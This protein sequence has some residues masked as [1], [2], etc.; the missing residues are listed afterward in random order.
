MEGSAKEIYA[1]AQEANKEA[2]V[3]YRKALS[4]GAA[5][6][7]HYQEALP[8]FSKAMDLGLQAEEKDPGNKSIS[9]FLEKVN[10]Y[11]YSCF[12]HQTL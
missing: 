7:Q 8:L 10:M 9:S 3:I 12:K 5:A 6:T 1:A 4:G 2:M 11:R